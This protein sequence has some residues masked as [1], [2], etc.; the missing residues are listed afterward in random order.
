MVLPI[1]DPYVLHHGALG[2]FAWVYLPDADRERA[3]A[4]F[5]ALDGV[6]EVY[7]REEAAVIYEHPADRIGDLT[8]ASDARTA[9]G[10]ARAKH[11]LSLVSRRAALARRPARADRA[12]RGEPSPEPALRSVARG[13]RPE[14]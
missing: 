7:P 3:R 5:V 10:K 2:S 1:T 4:A 6:E 13:R 8:V 12:D 11:D 9:L 14:P